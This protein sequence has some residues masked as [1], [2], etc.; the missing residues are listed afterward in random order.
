MVHDVANGSVVADTVVEER[1]KHFSLTQ[2]ADFVRGLVSSEQRASMQKH[3]D[4][5]CGRCAKTVRMWTSIVEFARLETTYEPPDGAFRIAESYLVPFKLALRKKQRL[6]LAR[7]TFDSFQH[8]A[9]QGVRGSDTVSRQFM[10][11]CGD[12]FIDMRRELKLPSNLMILAGQVVDSRQP[13]S[14]VADIPVSLVC[15]GDTLLETTTN[16]LGEFRF[17]FQAVKHLSVLF[18]TKEAALLVLLPDSETDVA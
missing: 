2:W 12:V 3:L 10:Y 8:Q 6:Q 13:A 11:Q 17:S 16:Q 4:Q 5:D 18:G 1:V 9:L 14:G 15:R 7:L